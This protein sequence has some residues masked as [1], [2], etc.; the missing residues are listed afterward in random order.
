[1]LLAAI[2]APLQHSPCILRYNEDVLRREGRAMAQICTP[3]ACARQ[4]ADTP[5]AERR[6]RLCRR[7]VRH[8]G[9]AVP[10]AAGRP[11]VG[12][13]VLLH[14]L[15][16]G[17]CRPEGGPRHP[18]RPAA[19]GPGRL[20]R[21]GHQRGPQAAAFKA[22]MCAKAPTFLDCA[23]RAVV[24]VQSSSSFGGIVEPN[25]ASNGT[26]VNQSRPPSIPAPPARWC[27]SRS[28]IPGSSAASCRSSR[29]ATSAT[30]RMLMQAS[31]A[32]RTEPYN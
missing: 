27:W 2:Y 23:N 25:C 11:D 17:K 18:H 8:R 32:F 7:R 26:M 3:R 13:S 29:S 20:C 5:L 22:S 15:H 19:A 6:A 30:A 28:A 14:E 9:H 1:M 21:H 10:A 24:L 31:A 4:A 12:I 16:H